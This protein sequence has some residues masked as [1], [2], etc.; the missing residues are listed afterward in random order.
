MRRE[1]LKTAL[2][3]GSLFAAVASVA[4]VAR[5]TE[6]L[7]KSEIGSD[8]DDEDQIVD[9]AS[10]EQRLAAVL[11]VNRILHRAINEKKEMLKKSH[12]E[13]TSLRNLT[14]CQSVEEPTRRSQIEDLQVRLQE[15]EGD[16]KANRDMRFMAREI[17]RLET[18]IGKLNEE[19]LVMADK[20]RLDRQRVVEQQGRLRTLAKRE[21]ELTKSLD[22]LATQLNDELLARSYGGTSEDIEAVHLLPLMVDYRHLPG[23][24]LNKLCGKNP[25]RE[26][27]SVVVPTVAPAEAILNPETLPEQ[28]NESE[29]R[30][31]S[32][33][34]AALEVAGGEG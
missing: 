25:Q 30:V 19:N 10:P 9:P 4:K 11:E 20:H 24:N 33:T 31:E 7:Q 5:E 32:E 1:S 15:A 18:K 34:V 26:P 16:G 14:D 13:A 12:E 21:R 6:E 22:F 3:P 27:P 23:M 17:Q 8:D 2:Q 28:R 29:L